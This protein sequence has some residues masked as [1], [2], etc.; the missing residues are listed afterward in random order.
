MSLEKQPKSQ[1]GGKRPN[2]G[3][4]PGSTQKI[5][6]KDILAEAENMLGMP[7]VRSLMMGYMKTV[8]EDDTRNRVIYEKMLLDKVA[9]QLLDVENNETSTVENRQ[10]AFLKALETIGTVSLQQEQDSDNSDQD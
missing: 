7:F 3:R 8:Q 2:S 9:S 6:A 10:H 4:K 1:H 5:T